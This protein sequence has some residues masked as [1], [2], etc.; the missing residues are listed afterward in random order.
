MG[1]TR[2]RDDA[3]FVVDNN[4]PL[5]SLS[6]SFSTSFSSFPSLR[7]EEPSPGH[8]PLERQ[9]KGKAR[10]YIRASSNSRGITSR[11]HVSPRAA[12][13]ENATRSRG[14]LF[15]GG[16]RKRRGR[17]RETY[18]SANGNDHG[19]RAHPTRADAR[20]RPSYPRT[21]T[22]V[23]SRSLARTAAPISIFFSFERRGGKESFSTR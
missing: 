13:D 12:R 21:T 23:R 18:T 4:R 11:R 10:A 9:E 1:G 6:T 2:L 17:H 16:A 19:T 20:E 7:E 14:L 22:S 3:V 15:A 5:S 8:W